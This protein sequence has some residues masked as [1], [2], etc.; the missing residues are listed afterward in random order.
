MASPAGA[1]CPGLFLLRMKAHAYMPIAIQLSSR[2]LIELLVN[3]SSCH[4]AGARTSAG[5][6]EERGQLVDTADQGRIAGPHV[7]PQVGLVEERA[8][9]DKSPQ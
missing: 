7:L 2:L 4:V 6:T 8:V 5:T 1:P 3:G 9:G